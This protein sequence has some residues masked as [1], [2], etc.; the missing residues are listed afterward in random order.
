MHD[1][2][3]KEKHDLGKLNIESARISILDYNSRLTEYRHPHIN[4][5]VQ[6]DCKR[7]TRLIVEENKN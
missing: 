5:E 1:K 3:A 2:N 7:S 6:T 4:Y